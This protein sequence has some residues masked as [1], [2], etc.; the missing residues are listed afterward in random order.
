MTSRTPDQD[1]TPSAHDRGRRRELVTL[2]VIAGAAASLS[3]TWLGIAAV[4]GAAIVPRD[5]DGTTVAP[6]A[7]TAPPSSGGIEATGGTLLVPVPQPAT[8]VPPAAPVQPARRS[9][10][11]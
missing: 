10:A 2:S 6:V 5:T 8:T 1:T 9:R 11:S 3:V 7:V 4:D